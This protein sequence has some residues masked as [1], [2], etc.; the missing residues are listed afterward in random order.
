MVRN[1][2]RDSHQL[3][4]PFALQRLAA[5]NQRPAGNTKGQAA[6]CATACIKE[7]VTSTDRLK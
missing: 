4:G 3:A 2:A 6:S 5:A 1:P 7:S